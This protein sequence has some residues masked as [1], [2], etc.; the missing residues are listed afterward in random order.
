MVKL[1]TIIVRIKGDIYNDVYSFRDIQG[2]IDLFNE[3]HSP[4]MILTV[5]EI[6]KTE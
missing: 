2:H 5:E 1:K 3:V 6:E 4:Q